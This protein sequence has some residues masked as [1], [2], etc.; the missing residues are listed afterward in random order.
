MFLSSVQ[1]VKLHLWHLV[2]VVM[3]LFFFFSVSEFISVPNA[4]HLSRMNY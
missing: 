1:N 4:Q 3:A 2:V